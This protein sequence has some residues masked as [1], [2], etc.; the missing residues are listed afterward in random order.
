MFQFFNWNWFIFL[1][2]CLCEIKWVISIFSQKFASN[3]TRNS[4][5]TNFSPFTLNQCCFFEVNKLQSASKSILDFIN[6]NNENFS[7]IFQVSI[8]FHFLVFFSFFPRWKII[9]IIFFNVNV[10][11]S[12]MMMKIQWSSLFFFKFYVSNLKIQFSQLI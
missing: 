6:G 1:T 5:F 3:K 8:S 11:I 9:S 12:W 10:S 7:K 4:G 2:V